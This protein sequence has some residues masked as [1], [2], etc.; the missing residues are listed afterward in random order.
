MT[1][2]LIVIGVLALLIAGIL[3]LRATV[4]IKYIDEFALTVKVLFLNLR[5]LPAKKKEINP[6][7]YSPRKFRRMIRKK[8]KLAEKRRKKAEKK[9]AKKA[10]K[11]AKKAALEEK[12]KRSGKALTKK[13]RD[14][15]DIVEIVGLVG[16]LLEV[17]FRRFARH[18]QIK[19]ARLHITVASDEAAKTACMYGAVSQGVAYILELLGRVTNLKYSPDA[20]VYVAVDFTAEKPSADLEISFSLSVWQL[21][22]VIL[23]TGARFISTSVKNKIK[24]K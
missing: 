20:D 7:D 5:I 2:A 21:L 3:L 4:T 24:N 23:R 14:L 22:D 11:K 15:S 8:E 12:A 19:V 6:D 1:A 13:K 9:A 10:A 16:E 18:L 17:F